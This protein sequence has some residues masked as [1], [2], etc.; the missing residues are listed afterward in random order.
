MR[1]FTVQA[2][3]KIGEGT[4]N[5]SNDLNYYFHSD[6]IAACLTLF[7]SSVATTR[8]VMVGGT[9]FSVTSRP[10]CGEVTFLL[11]ETGE[12]L[13]LLFLATMSPRFIIMVLGIINT[14]EMFAKLER[15]L[16]FRFEIPFEALSFHI[17]GF[18][19]F[20]IGLK[21]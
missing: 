19:N 14:I 2:V 12:V 7:S 5:Q 16:H 20:Y 10:I 6:S 9:V 15:H 21:H 4:T 3:R 13:V 8:L 17:E 11:L 18:I 1:R